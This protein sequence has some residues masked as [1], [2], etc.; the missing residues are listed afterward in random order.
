MLN[1]SFVMSFEFVRSAE[2]QLGSVLC[3]P[4]ALAAY[5]SAVLV[6]EWI[7]QKFMGRSSDIGEDRA[8]TNMIKTR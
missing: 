6:P 7:N 5:R 1:V 2:S 4:G 3:T 8:M